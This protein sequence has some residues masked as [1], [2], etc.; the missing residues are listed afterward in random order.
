MAAWLS[1]EVF[2]VLLV[3]ARIGAALMVMPGFSAAYIST[4]VRALIAFAVAL[5]I[6]PLV[7]ASLPPRPDSPTALMLIVGGEIIIGGFLGAVTRILVAALHIAGTFIAFFGSLANALVQDAASDQQTS[8]VAGL[9]T[10]IGVL[11]IFVTDLHHLFFAA[12]VESYAAFPP[13][14]A[15]AAGDM[16]EALVRA[17]ADSILLGLQL[18]APFLLLGFVYG[19]GLGILGR[20]MPQLPVFFFG[21]PIQLS[22]QIW[23]LM[24]TLSVISLTFLNWFGDA[25]W[26]FVDRLGG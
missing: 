7:A 12:L 25:M 14:G 16:A 9:L 10:T 22:L 21:L 3:I 11:L 23:L 13:A 19:A 4:R 1:D 15:L 6:A 18:S 24:L 26:T 17:L 8:T 20:L 5:V 2:A